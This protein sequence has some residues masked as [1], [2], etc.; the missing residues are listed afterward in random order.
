MV[1]CRDRDD[2]ALLLVFGERC[3]LVQHAARLERAC[4]LQ[5]LGLEQ[6]VRTHLLGKRCRTE[7]RRSMKPVADTLARTVDVVQRDQ[8]IRR[9]HRE[10]VL[11]PLQQPP[12]T[13]ADEDGQHAEADARRRVEQGQAEGFPLDEAVRSCAKVENVV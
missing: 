11:R 8:R 12:D 6:D 7:H 4:A 2:A 1:P 9:S 3:E 13:R 10:I 5:E